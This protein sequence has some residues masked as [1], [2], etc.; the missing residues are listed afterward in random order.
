MAI[1]ILQ[2]GCVKL[3]WAWYDLWV[4]F[5]IDKEKN[6]L[7]F[8]PLP[9]ILF[10]L[11]LRRKVKIEVRDGVIMGERLKGKI[12]DGNGLRAMFKDEILQSGDPQLKKGVRNIYSKEKINGKWMQNHQTTDLETGNITREEINKILE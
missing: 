8:C 1:K 10:S 2:F 3:S 9:T 11:C 4:G 6:I 5:F 12:R 7:Y